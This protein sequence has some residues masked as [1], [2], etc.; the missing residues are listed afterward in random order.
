MIHRYSHNGVTWIDSEIPT[1]EEIQGL[2]EEFGLDARIY[3]ELLVETF[4]PHVRQFSNCL[5]L[6]LHF[7]ALKHSHNG[8]RRQ[9]I[10]FV[11]G[12]NFL[13]T[14]RFDTVDSL[15]K[16]SKVF[17]VESITDTD[18]SDDRDAD[19]KTL[20][21]RVMRKLYRSV[22]HELDFQN[23]ELLEIETHLFDGQESE[24]LVRL[25]RESL[26]LLIIEQTLAMHR[27]LLISLEEALT[28]FWGESDDLLS[29][30]IMAEYE[31]VSEKAKINRGLVDELRKT[32]DSI[33]ANK[34]NEIAKKL[35]VIATVLLPATLIAGLFGM[36]FIDGGMPFMDSPYGFYL[37]L[38]LMG[39][40]SLFFYL[41]FKYKRWF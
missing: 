37:T 17:E 15:H 36:N 41:L 18:P 4:R 28:M 25:S 13:I 20:F 33:L 19:V 24:T 39:A 21:Y 8:N 12:P 14:N 11:I 35:T 26:N 38:L 31:K 30:A 6:V 34:Q 16:L 27:E 29:A 5:Y 32:N 9:E 22:M 7:P 10:D 40:V 23:D 2:I 3:D 1:A